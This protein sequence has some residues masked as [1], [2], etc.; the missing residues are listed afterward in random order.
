MTIEEVMDA[1]MKSDKK[2]TIKE[3]AE[4][5]FKVI[6]LLDQHSPNFKDVQKKWREGYNGLMNT[7]TLSVATTLYTMGMNEEDKM[8]FAKSL[9]GE[10]IK[11][12]G[13]AVFKT[14]KDWEA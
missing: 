12:I 1:L 6:Y 14:R 9:E 13:I 5:M 7:L 8:L 2:F 10:P 11:A 3:I 4:D